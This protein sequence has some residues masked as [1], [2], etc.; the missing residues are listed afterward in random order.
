MQDRAAI[1]D[2]ARKRGAD[3]AR[4]LGGFT[5]I[6]MVVVVTLVLV[7]LGLLLPAA[8]TMWSERRESEAQNAL[9]GLLM[10]T[11]AHAMRADGVESGLFAFLDQTGAQHLVSIQR[12]RAHLA[13]PIWQNVF[14]ITAQRDHVLPP[15]MRVAPRYAVDDPKDV[16]QDDSWKVFSN[17][18]LAN[19]AFNPPPEDNTQRHRNYFTIVFSTEGHLIPDRDVLI[20]DEDVDGDGLGDRTALRVSGP[21]DSPTVSR[22]LARNN[23]GPVPIDPDSSDPVIPYLVVDPGDVAINFPSVRGVLVYDDVA[24][25]ELLTEEKQDFLLR[26]ATPLYLSR[27]TGTVVRGSAEGEVSGDE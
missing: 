15:P 19:D 3:R 22:H 18:E 5:L 24:F 9:E 23:D 26:E 6:E 16:S 20:L 2:D 14:V 25:H 4:W 17:I 21:P 8:H 1:I 11:R 13:E 7:I 10:T 12:P 27:W